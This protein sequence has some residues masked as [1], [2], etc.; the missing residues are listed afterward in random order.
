MKMILIVMLIMMTLVIEIVLMFTTVYH[1]RRTSFNGMVLLG[2]LGVILNVT[3][4][5][6]GPG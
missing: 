1:T 2:L 6:D 5:V 4:R 3:V